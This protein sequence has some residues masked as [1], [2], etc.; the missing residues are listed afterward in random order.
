MELPQTPVLAASLD[1][2]S[3]PSRPGLPAISDTVQSE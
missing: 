2:E 1:M 3:E